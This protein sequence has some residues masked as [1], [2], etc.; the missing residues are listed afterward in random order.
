MTTSN[1]HARAARETKAAKLAL[2]L[3]REF[4][5]DALRAAQLA[6]DTQWE[7]IAQAA[8]T[9]V[10]SAETRQRVRELLTPAAADPNDFLT[11]RNRMADRVMAGMR[12]FAGPEID[13]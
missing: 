13:L 9:H 3:Q 5:A 4:G 7:C 6:T 10:P 11:A 1:P 2:W 12:A 8:G